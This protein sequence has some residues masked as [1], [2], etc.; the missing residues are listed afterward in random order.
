[1]NKTPRPAWPTHP[2]GRK[3]TVGDMTQAELDAVLGP[4]LDDLQDELNGP[5]SPFVVLLQ[6]AA[7][8]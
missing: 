2:N 1:M 5:Q 6:K 8:Q 7:K 3:K 4:I